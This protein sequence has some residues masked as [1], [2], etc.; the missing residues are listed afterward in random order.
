MESK[1][2][3]VQLTPSWKADSTLTLEPLTPPISPRCTL[4]WVQRLPLTLPPL[5]S[6]Y[7]RCHQHLQ[8]YLYFNWSCCKSTW[9][10]VPLLPWIISAFLS[11]LLGDRKQVC[12]GR[13]WGGE[14]GMGPGSIWSCVSVSSLLKLFKPTSWTCLLHSL[15]SPSKDIWGPLCIHNLV[16]KQIR[17]TYK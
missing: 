6:P 12:G 9:Y 14:R 10:L 15:A 1:K 17:M 13:G 5:F 11:N 7:C 3:N 8:C 2:D 4:E 16:M